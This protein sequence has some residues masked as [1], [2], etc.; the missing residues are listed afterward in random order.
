MAGIHSKARKSVSNYTTSIAF[1]IL[2][3]ISTIA[4]YAYN[5]FLLWKIEEID[6]T[7]SWYETSIKAITMRKDVQ[8]YSLLE[9]NKETISEYENMN[10]ITEFIKHMD[11]IQSVYDVEMEGFRMSNWEIETQVTVKSEE[12]GDLNA[13]HSF[14]KEFVMKYRLDELSKFDLLFINSFF[15]DMDAIKFNV[16]FKIK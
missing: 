15:W 11:K 12:D 16:N 3:V 5:S 13:A 1:L 6:S 8:I 9:L 2:V 10:R 7:I 14:I 4:L